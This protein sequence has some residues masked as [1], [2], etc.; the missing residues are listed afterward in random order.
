MFAVVIDLPLFEPLC[1]VVKFSIRLSEGL[2]ADVELSPLSTI[3]LQKY[4]ELHFLSQALV[5]G[6]R[7]F[8]SFA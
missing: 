8:L 5:A 4:R 1:L 2:A 3:H 7:A 6:L